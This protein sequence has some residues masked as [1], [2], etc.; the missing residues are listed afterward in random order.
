MVV[1]AW[2]V[3]LRRCTTTLPRVASFLPV[4]PAFGGGGHGYGRRPSH[5]F[6]KA[7]CPLLLLIRPVLNRSVLTGRGGCKQRTCVHGILKV[8]QCTHERCHF[9]N[10]CFDPL[11]FLPNLPSRQHDN[12]SCPTYRVAH[13]PSPPLA[14]WLCEKAAGWDPKLAGARASPCRGAF[15][16]IWTRPGEAGNPRP[17]R[18]R[19]RRG[20]RCPQ[21]W[22]RLL[23]TACSTCGGSLHVC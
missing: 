8:A 21:R 15:Q 4:G 1:K 2:G 23:H 22:W 9:R 5:R 6:M 17:S 16:T 10:V 14:H 12:S 13:H 19:R 18:G 3:R 20:R 11:P 7:A